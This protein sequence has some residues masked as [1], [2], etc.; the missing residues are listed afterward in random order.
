MGN[1]GNEERLKEIHEAYRILGD[2]EQRRGYD[3]QYRHPFGTYAF[4]KG[5]VDD[6]LITVLRRFSEMGPGT[7]WRT[8]DALCPGGV[9]GQKALKARRSFRMPPP[10]FG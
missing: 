10:L 8:R 4:G 3:I 9:K 7:N 2:E 5:G 6:D 1:S